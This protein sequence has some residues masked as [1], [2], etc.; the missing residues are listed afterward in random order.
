MQGLHMNVSLSD[1]EGAELLLVTLTA[2][3]TTHITKW[4]W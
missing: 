3:G 2:N 4:L 1:I